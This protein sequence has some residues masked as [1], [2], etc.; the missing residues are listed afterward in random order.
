MNIIY[1]G[2]SV[3][4]VNVARRNGKRSNAI[5]KQ[6]INFRFSK[7]CYL[8]IRSKKTSREGQ[9]ENLYYRLFE[10]FGLNNRKLLGYI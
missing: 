2:L 9:L 8:T 10:L 4:R 5:R 6:L 3:F 1:D 7:P